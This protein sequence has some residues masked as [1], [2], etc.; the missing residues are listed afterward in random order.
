MISSVWLDLRW[1]L[2]YFRFGYFTFFLGSAC[3]GSDDGTLVVC[4]GLMLLNL[5]FC[6]ADRCRTKQWLKLCKHFT[7]VVFLH[8]VTNNL[9]VM[10]TDPKTKPFFVGLSIERVTISPPSVSIRNLSEILCLK[11]ILDAIS[12]ENFC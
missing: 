7:I 3:V 11:V 2:S 5:N 9:G 10:S 1:Q 8:L 12:V 6:Y 4:F